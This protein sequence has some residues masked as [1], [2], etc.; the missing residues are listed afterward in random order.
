MTVYFAR[1]ILTALLCG[2]ALAGCG[3]DGDGGNSTQTLSVS[4]TGNG[5]VRSQPAGIDCGSAGIGCNASY[6]GASAVT[7]TAV[8]GVAS[9]FAAWG[10][11]CSGTALTCVVTMDEARS[12]TASF[13]A[14]PVMQ[15]LAVTVSG[16]GRVTSQPS[17]IDCGATCSGSFAQTVVVTLT[18]APAA[19]Q[20]FS[21]WGGACSG[22]S[23]SCTVTLAAASTVTATFVLTPPTAFALAVS[24]AGSGAVTSL[25]AGINCG[26]TCTTNFV[27]GTSVTLTAAPAAGQSFSAWGDD[28][29]GAANTCV[30][31]MD[32]ARTVSATFVPLSGQ[33]NFSLTV[34]V[35][36]S[37]TVESSPAGISCGSSCT[38]S[39]LAGTNVILTATAA[40]GQ[41]FSGWSGAC[42]G[43]QSTCSVSLTQARTVGAV[44]AATS[45]SN[46]LP[47]QLLES[48]NDFNIGGSQVAING[49]GDAIAIW[50][51]SDGLPNGATFKVYSRRYQPTGGWQPAVTVAGLTRSSSNPSL[52]TDGRLLLDETGVATW[53]REDLETRRNS[54]ATGWGTAFSPPDLRV[55]QK[56]TSAVID[57]NGV[58]L[59]M[60]AGS[61]V[62]SNTLPASGSW[63]AWTRVDNAGSAISAL[64]QVALSTNGTAL[65]VWRESNPG[66]GNYSMKA[67]KF[68]PNVGWGVPES[69]ETLVTDV[70]DA[71]ANI[72]IDAQ[73]NGIA[74]WQQGN[75][76]TVHYNIYRAA[77]GWQGAVEI[78][79]EAQA[80]A[81]ANIQLAMTPDGRAVAT[82]RIGGGLGTLRSM[83]YTPSAGWTNPVTVAGSNTG[84][85]MFID[86]TGQAI[87]VYQVIDATTARWDL[88]A[89]RLSFGGAWS[90]ATSLESADGSIVND[91]FAMNANGK[92]VAIWVQNDAA[93]SSVRNSLWSAILN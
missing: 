13:A 30:V 90:A 29:S 65:A 16:D 23:P 91:T 32:Q 87:M 57:A 28:C 6:A 82:W 18:A 20:S 45:A 49:N 36:G 46:W 27:A 39:F 74:M 73:G 24:L 69:I 33:T 71:N 88:F 4:V 77:S 72:A 60:R 80:L 25:P 41:V 21:A 44:F 66:D 84:R 76:P 26:T 59:A 55:S 70:S 2:L 58:I 78:P 3:R 43:T 12:V 68:T 31:P 35:A 85:R 40:A 51:Q 19:G 22:T 75:N 52:I 63:G 53:I 38:A 89:R 48:N 79:T 1:T 8:P 50:E 42:S 64:A 15:T 54:P 47:A 62:E 83:Q 86:T 9:T 11:V 61:D 93:N 10:G 67:A 56:L 81:T 17:G 92:G 5:V 37:G 34:N 7:L 14:I